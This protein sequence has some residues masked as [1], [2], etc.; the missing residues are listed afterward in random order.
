MWTYTATGHCRTHPS[1]CYPSLNSICT[2]MWK[3][4]CSQM[5][6]QQQYVLNGHHWVCF[7]GKIIKTRS[8]CMRNRKCHSGHR[9]STTLSSNL[10]RM[11]I[12]HFHPNL[13][14]RTRCFGIAGLSCEIGGLMCRFLKVAG[15]QAR[16]QRLKIAP[17]I[18]VCSSDPGA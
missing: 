17:S 8:D 18:A 16:R 5:L 15:C 13:P 1:N 3:L 11:N 10:Q 4:C 12:I 6:A 14:G 2:F 9:A 7:C